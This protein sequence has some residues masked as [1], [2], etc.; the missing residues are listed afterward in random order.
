MGVT[1]FEAF[2]ILLL[3]LAD[4]ILGSINHVFI[5]KNNLSALAISSIG[6]KLTLDFMV[7][8]LVLFS[9]VNDTSWFSGDVDTLINT[10]K[11]V[12]APIVAALLY[13]ELT[14]VLKHVQIIIGID[15]SKYVPGL[16][17][18]MKGKQKHDD[19]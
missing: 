2:A 13:Y 3:T 5:K 10:Y 6:K 9:H 4:I 14:S 19:N 17:S 12:I 18:E 15:F 16:K 1:E 7:L 11:V 8:A